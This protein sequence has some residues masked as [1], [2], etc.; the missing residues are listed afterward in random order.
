MGFLETDGSARA[1]SRAG[2]R[3]LQARGGRPQ[4]VPE[5]RPRGR[6]DKMPDAL[7][8]LVRDEDDGSP[9]RNDGSRIAPL[10][11]EWLMDLQVLGRSPRTI[12]WYEQ[13]VN[14]YLRESA[15]ASLEELTAFEFKRYPAQAFR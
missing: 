4:Q 7:A 5:G 3:G 13:K 11:R 6:P 14:T 15:I 8:A 2:W 10:V 12:R 9:R 1:A